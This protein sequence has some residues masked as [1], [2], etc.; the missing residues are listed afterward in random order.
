MLRD[1]HWPACPL[2]DGD[3]SRGR[4]PEDISLLCLLCRKKPFFAFLSACFYTAVLSGGIRLFNFCLCWRS[5]CASFLLI[6]VCLSGPLCVDRKYRQ[7]CTKWAKHSQ[8]CF[9]EDRIFLKSVPNPKFPRPYFT[10]LMSH[11]CE[12][13]VGLIALWR[14]L[15]EGVGSDLCH[16][17]RVTHKNSSSVMSTRL[18]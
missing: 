16:W 12:S 14:L 5:L 4:T 8:R 10:L 15:S 6:A 13:T 11:A 3:F 17:Y 1:P 2:S 7:L 18:R 9:S